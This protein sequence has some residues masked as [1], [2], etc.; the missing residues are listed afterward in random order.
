M[1]KRLRN[2]DASKSRGKSDDAAI[3]EMEA[4]LTTECAKLGWMHVT[5]PRVL[6]EPQNLLKKK[7]AEQE[8]EEKEED[9]E[10]E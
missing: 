8:E 6:Q 10:S 7:E 3:T 1:E 9:D 2:P 5:K 4:I